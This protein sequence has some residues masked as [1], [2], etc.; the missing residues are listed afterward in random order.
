MEESADLQSREVDNAVNVR[1]RRK[2]LVKSF[3]ICD[4]DLVEVWSLSAEKLDTVKGNLGR[5]VEAV[6]NYNLIAM[7]EESKGCERPDIP[8]ASVRLNV[9]LSR[10]LVCGGAG[11]SRLAV[12]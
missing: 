1:V 3:F 10:I 6:D 11:Q 8:G 9:S 5:V 4:I 2:D 12:V 7:F